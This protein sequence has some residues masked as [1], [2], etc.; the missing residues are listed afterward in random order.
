MEIHWV[1]RIKEQKSEPNDTNIIL[2][3]LGSWEHKTYNEY[4]VAK[5]IFISK[6]V[7]SISF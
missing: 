6:L 1:E 4:A 3:T 2:Y 7:N 5:T